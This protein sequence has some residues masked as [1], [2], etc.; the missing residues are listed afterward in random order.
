MT[1]NQSDDKP[2]TTPPRNW[3]I[4]VRGSPDRPMVAEYLCPVHGRFTLEVARDANGDPP[5]EMACPSAVLRPPA[6]VTLADPRDAEHFGV[7]ATCRLPSPFAISATRGA[8]VRKVEV[9]RGGYQKPEVPTWTNTENLGEGQAFEDWQDD[10][11]KVW[12]RAREDEVK[13]LQRELG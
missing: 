5:A 4:I 10:R 12:E 1:T 11:D 9:V 3:K 7:R 6:L 13:E 8:R 2:E